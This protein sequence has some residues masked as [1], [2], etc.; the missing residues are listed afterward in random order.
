MEREITK[1]M[2]ERQ[3]TASFP[4]NGHG[5][6]IQ[7]QLAGLAGPDGSHAAETAMLLSAV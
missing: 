7:L 6:G 1:R 4:T 2:V 5:S 3:S